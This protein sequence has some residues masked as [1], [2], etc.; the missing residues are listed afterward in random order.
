MIVAEPFVDA[1]GC[2]TLLFGSRR[3][4]IGRQD[5]I[6]DARERPELG[7][8]GDL[9]EVLVLADLCQASAQFQVEKLNEAHYSVRR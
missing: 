4:G 8:C 6:D 5:L 9:V 2:V 3:I 7:R 1:L